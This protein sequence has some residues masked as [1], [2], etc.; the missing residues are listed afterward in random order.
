MAKVKKI[1]DPGY[2]RRELY[3]Q[4]ST[5]LAHRDQLKPQKAQ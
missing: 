5:M 4:H 2:L 1:Y 3:E